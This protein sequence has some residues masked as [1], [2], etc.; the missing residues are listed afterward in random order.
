MKGCYFY[1]EATPTSSRLRALYK[2]SRAEFPDARLQEENRRRSR[3]DGAFE[4]LETGVLDS[5][6]YFDVEAVY[7]KAGPDDLCIEIT[8]SNRGPEAA[9]LHAFPLRWFRN[10]CPWACTQARGEVKPKLRA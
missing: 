1:L 3:D 10:I 9:E 4:P 5:G 8:V 2:Y 7:K 6:R